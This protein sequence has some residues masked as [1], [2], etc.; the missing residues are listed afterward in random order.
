MLLTPQPPQL[1]KTGLVKKEK[2]ATA[3]ANEAIQPRRGK[4]VWRVFAH[5]VAIPYPDG[6]VLLLPYLYRVKAAALFMGDGFIELRLYLQLCHANFLRYRSH[7]LVHHLNDHQFNWPSSNEQPVK[8]HEQPATGHEVYAL[9]Y[10]VDADGYVQQF[11]CR[12]YLLLLAAELTGCRPSMV[13][14]KVCY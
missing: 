5:V 8:R 12:A 13:H 11:P 3:R 10:A 9:H 7:Q 1:V 6:H 4:P 2:I 14:S